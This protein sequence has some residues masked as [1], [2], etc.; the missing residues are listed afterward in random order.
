MLERRG[1][2]G[3]EEARRAHL[4]R[5]AAQQARRLERRELLAHVARAEG[6]EA[7]EQR[8]LGDA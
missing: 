7:L 2:A 1:L 8:R 4:E 6:G 3:T 5:G